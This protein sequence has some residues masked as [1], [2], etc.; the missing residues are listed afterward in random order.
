[1]NGD[2]VALGIFAV[3]LIVVAHLIR[4]GKDFTSWK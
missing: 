1:M 2:Y 4:T 3:V